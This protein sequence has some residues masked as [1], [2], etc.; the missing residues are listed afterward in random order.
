M[1]FLEFVNFG[2]RNIGNLR[3]QAIVRLDDV[4]DQVPEAHLIAS[5]PVAE[6]VGRNGVDGSEDVFLPAGQGRAQHG[7]EGI[8][9][10][11]HALRSCIRSSGRS[12]GPRLGQRRTGKSACK[13]EREKNSIHFE[14]PFS[15]L[16]AATDRQ[17][18]ET[19]WD[20]KQP[21]SYTHRD[22]CR[23]IEE[24][25]Q[26]AATNDFVQ[27]PDVARVPPDDSR[28]GRGRGVRDGSR[29]GAKALTCGGRRP[30]H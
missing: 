9:H 1:G 4:D 25:F 20:Q 6:L 18:V 5:G 2:G 17:A 3:A 12:W 14:F 10:W 13:T 8:F 7:A 28:F 29:E 15:Y 24:I 19:F 16:I 11:R 27:E 30:Y 26:R 22:S 21:K 23:R